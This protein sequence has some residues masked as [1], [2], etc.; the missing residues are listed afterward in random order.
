MLFFFDTGY[1]TQIVLKIPS[2]T[3]FSHFFSKP[4]KTLLK[5][6]NIYIPFPNHSISNQFHFKSFF[7]CK[8]EGR[9]QHVNKVNGDRKQVVVRMFMTGKT[10]MYNYYRKRSNPFF[11]NVL[12]EFGALLSVLESL[13]WEKSGRRDP[14]GRGKFLFIRYVLFSRTSL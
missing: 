10:N 6:F 11:T 3:R 13:P 1:V 7:F 9:K 2:E 14:L 8:R 4:C 5:T 12:T